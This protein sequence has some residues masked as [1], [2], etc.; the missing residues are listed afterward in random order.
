MRKISSPLKVLVNE[1]E[2]IPYKKSMKKSGPILTIILLLL[3]VAGMG[4]AAYFYQQWNTLKQNPQAT[5]QKEAEQLVGRV[6]RLIVL[7]EGEVPTIATVQDPELL[8]EQLFFANA[9]KGDKVL[10]YT[11]ARKAILYD[12]VSNKIVEVAPVNIG[13]PQGVSGES[14]GSEA[15]TSAP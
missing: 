14:S 9:K 11:N 5:V 7:P 13:N 8:K 3:A 12:P 4:A 1:P 6:S 15:E 10:I 2:Q